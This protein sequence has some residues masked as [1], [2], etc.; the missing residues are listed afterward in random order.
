MV[1]PVLMTLSGITAAALVLI[2]ILAVIFGLLCLFTGP[3]LC[4]VA[5]SC[6]VAIW[7]RDC[8]GLLAVLAIRRWKTPAELVAPAP[9]R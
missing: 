3:A 1:L 5:S 8:A 7:L 2:V 6:I 9:A 4:I